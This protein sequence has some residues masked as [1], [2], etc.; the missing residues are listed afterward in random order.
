MVVVPGDEGRA[1][2]S[3]PGGKKVAAGIGDEGDERRNASIGGASGEMVSVSG[4]KESAAG[5]SSSDEKTVSGE[6]MQAIDVA[7][8]SMGGARVS[9]ESAQVG[10]GEPSE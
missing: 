1:A 8:T 9:I 7:A 4:G 6:W 2:G 3:S 10:G 5:S